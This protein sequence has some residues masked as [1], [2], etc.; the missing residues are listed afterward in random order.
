M[1]L[2]VL[3]TLLLLATPA[4]AAAQT[5]P[6]VPGEFIVQFAPGADRAAALREHGG[7][8]VDRIAGLDATVVR[9][10]ADR[11][12]R[13]R[14]D[15]R[16]RTFEPNFLLHALATP[17]DPLY[18]TS[19]WGP[20]RIGAE[21]AWDV[22]R[23][24]AGVVVAVVDSGVDAAH[25]DLAGRV[26]AGIDLVTPGGPASDGNGHG[27]HVAGTVAAAMDGTGVVGVCPGCSVLPVKVLG[28]DG[29]GTT[30]GV[31][32]GILEAAAAGAEVINLSLGGPASTTLQQAV[33]TAAGTAFLACA[34]GNDGTSSTSTAYPGAYASCF[35]VASTTRTDARSSFSNYGSWVEVAAPGSD[36]ASTWTGSTYRTISGTSMATPH[37]AG[38][39]GLMASQGLGPATTRRRLC[40]TAEPIAGTGS[41]WTCGLADAR[42]AVAGDPFL[43]QDGAWTTSGPARVSGGVAALGGVDG[44]TATAAQAFVVPANARLTFRF[45]RRTSETTA[46]ARDRLVVRLRSRGG[47]VLETLATFS[48]ASGP[49]TVTVPLGAHADRAAVL[50]L[51]AT[52]DGAR[53][54]TFLVDQVSVG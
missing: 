9:L 40:G 39:A 14:A 54:T 48:N 42:L 27:T 4:A 17:T 45:D 5:A 29:R 41:L 8:R 23:G 30:A 32:K 13:A 24:D 12:E 37:V 19:Q 34:A 49:T 52:S 11:A 1:R 10:P 2:P 47:A 46:K 3:V 16:F 22:A 18:L 31:A 15:R 35:A 38:L 43:P 53:P 26:L 28:D 33:D 51:V 7:R 50:E 25:P 36:I 20:Q 21:G 6:A 44:A